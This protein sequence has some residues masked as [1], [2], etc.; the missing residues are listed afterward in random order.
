MLAAVIFDLDGVLADSE[1]WWSQIDAQLLAK[2]GVM[3]R[4][5]HH[6]K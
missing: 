1:T 2:Y 6:Q 5:E 4:G 3:Y